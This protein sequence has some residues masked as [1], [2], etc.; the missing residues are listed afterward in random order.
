METVST[1]HR[2]RIKGI[3]INPNDY[4]AVG[5]NPQRKTHI[6]VNISK[7]N[8]MKAIMVAASFATM[9]AFFEYGGYDHMGA[10]WCSEVWQISR[11]YQNDNAPVRA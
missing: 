3:R 4:A 8:R 5:R 7:R 6:C 9:M 10:K 1:H 11:L 2:P